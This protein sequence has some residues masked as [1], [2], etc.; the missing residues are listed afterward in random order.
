MLLKIKM[1][2][3]KKK[4]SILEPRVPLNLGARERS[5]DGQNSWAFWLGGDAAGN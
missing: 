5:P 2:V 4:N 1:F 3:V